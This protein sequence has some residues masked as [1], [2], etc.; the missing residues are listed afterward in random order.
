[1][2][3]SFSRLRITGCAGW[4][5][6]PG[7]KYSRCRP[8]RTKRTVAVRGSGV[9]I[10]IA[11]LKVLASHGSGRATLASLKQDIVILSTS[12]PDWN[13]RIRRLARRVP[14]IDIFGAGYVLRD[15]EGWQIMPA[16]RAFLAELEAVTQDNRTAESDLPSLQEERRE[17]ALIVVGHRFKN[18]IRR[19][20]DPPLAQQLAQRRRPRH[21]SNA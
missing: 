10:Q 5:A 7:T 16:G 8:Q 13:A 20:R 6:A 12:G 4:T 17:G 3:K 9:S 18:R 21:D 14:A 15:D 1:M 19:D 11:I 2:R